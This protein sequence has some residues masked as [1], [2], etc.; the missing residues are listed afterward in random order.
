EVEGGTPLN[1][2][3]QVLAIDEKRIHFFH[4]LHRSDDGT[5]L[6]TAEQMQLHV[7]TRASRAVPADPEV[8]ARVQRIAAAHRPLARPEGSGRAISLA[9]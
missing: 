5:L 3:T 7:D 4:S 1:V 8:L 6:A 2:T 9:K